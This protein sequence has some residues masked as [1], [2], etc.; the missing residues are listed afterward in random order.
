LAAFA[1][2]FIRA[3]AGAFVSSLWAVGDEPATTFSHE[4]YAEL[5]DGSSVA[6]AAVAAREKARAAGDATWLAYVV[7]A[8][9]DAKLV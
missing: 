1:E 4:F 8:H 9:P 5:K 6:E 3:G 2:A 7:Y